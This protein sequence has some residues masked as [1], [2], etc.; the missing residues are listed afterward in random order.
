MLTFHYFFQLL[1]RIFIVIEV[2]AF[3][4]GSQE[5]KPMTVLVPDVTPNS[6]TAL[7]KFLYSDFDTE[8]ELGDDVM[9]TL[10]AGNSN[11]LIF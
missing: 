4:A 5:D 8:A 2:L 10:Y 7:V 9:Q 3:S 11:V 1:F 6:F